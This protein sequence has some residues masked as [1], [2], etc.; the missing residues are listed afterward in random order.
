MLKKGFAHL[1]WKFVYEFLQMYHYNKTPRYIN[2]LTNSKIQYLAIWE[3]IS[4]SK[5]NFL[6]CLNLQVYPIFL[7]NQIVN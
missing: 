4:I 3:S 7:Y 2:S 1:L 6:S 5:N